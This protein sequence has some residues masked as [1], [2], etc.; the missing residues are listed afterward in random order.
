[1]ADSHLPGIASAHCSKHPNLIVSSATLAAG[2]SM[3]FTAPLYAIRMDRAWNPARREVHERM[4]W[5]R[6][7]GPASTSHPQVDQPRLTFWGPL[8]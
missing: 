2:S 6:S 7:G 4:P 8:P 1:M 3:V 5:S